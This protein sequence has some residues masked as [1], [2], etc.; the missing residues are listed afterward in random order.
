VANKGKDATGVDTIQDKLWL[1]TAREM[2]GRKAL[3]TDY[4]TEAN[5]ARLE[6]YTSNA[7][8]AKYD[9]RNA[10]PKYWEASPFYDSNYYFCS[11]YG[12]GDTGDSGDTLSS[13]ELGCVPAF[14][15]Y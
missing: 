14:C 8:R 10:G 9:Y 13:S 6:Y 2:F 15:V 3:S 11:V 1:P 4:E 7:L 5:Q 12:D